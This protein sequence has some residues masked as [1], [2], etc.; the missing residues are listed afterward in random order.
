M[1]AVRS[2]ILE[3][4]NSQEYLKQFIS[5]ART[6]STEEMNQSRVASEIYMTWTLRNSAGALE[7]GMA[8]LGE[9]L[10][11]A[12][13]DHAEAL[14]RSAEAA[15]RHARGLKCATAALALATVA[16]VLVELVPLLWK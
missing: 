4:G 8:K 2:R 1:E 13:R 5:E 15:N 10:E 12:L 9:G 14:G 16:L 6:A 11:S 3:E 7:G